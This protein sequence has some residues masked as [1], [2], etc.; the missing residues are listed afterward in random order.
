MKTLEKTSKRF[1]AIREMQNNGRSISETSR[2]YDIPKS[3]LTS[4]WN[5]FN[6]PNN[7]IENKELY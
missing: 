3:T 4:W 5:K 7:E 6:D 1:L 2:K